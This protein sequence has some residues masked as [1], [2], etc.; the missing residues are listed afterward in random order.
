ADY[1][2]SKVRLITSI[3][4]ALAADKAKMEEERYEK[5]G[6]DETGGRII[7]AIRMN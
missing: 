6:V 7:R 2:Q 5:E 4:D 3:N 1:A